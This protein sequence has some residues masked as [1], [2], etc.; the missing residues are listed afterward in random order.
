MPSF[1]FHWQILSDEI[2]CDVLDMDAC[3]LV[4]GRPWQFDGNALHQGQDNTYSFVWKGRQIVLLPIS[5]PRYSKSGD[6]NKSTLYCTVLGP[7]FLK[8]VFP[9]SKLIAF[10]L[11]E[12]PQTQIKHS[13]IVC[14]LL[15][16]FVDLSPTGLLAELPPMRDIQH[17]IDL[18]PGASLP[19]LPHYQ[20][21]L[22]EHEILQSLVDD[23][24]QKKL[25]RPS[26]SPCAVPALLV[27][28]KDGT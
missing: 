3:Q 27:P 12:Q 26:L 19:N 2:T 15:Q 8:E 7:K 6:H 5:S 11:I 16:E 13:P 18:L 10:L 25:V 23:L 22:K 24:V 4:L 9:R 14:K 1:F 21:S 20:L 28:K 17:Q